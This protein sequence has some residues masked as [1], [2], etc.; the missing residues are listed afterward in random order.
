MGSLVLEAD[1][2]LK[3]P[4]KDGDEKTEEKAA[5][6]RAN[7]SGQELL[8]W[9]GLRTESL[10]TLPQLEKRAAV[11]GRASGILW[12]TTLYDALL[13]RGVPPDED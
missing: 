12:Y 5:R 2:A 3:N 7:P 13:T 6:L 8:I 4:Y 10:E 11:I 1:K 9:W